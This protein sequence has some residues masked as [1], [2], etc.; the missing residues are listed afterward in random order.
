MDSQVPCHGQ[1][2]PREALSGRSCHSPLDQVPG[3]VG[4]HRSRCCTVALLAVG[5]VP[6]RG[7]AARELCHQAGSRA[8]ALTATSCCPRCIPPRHGRKLAPSSSGKGSSTNIAAD[9][10]RAVSHG[11]RPR[12]G[13][14]QLTGTPDGTGTA[15]TVTA[16]ELDKEQ[17]DQLHA[18]TL[19]AA[20]TCFELKKLC[21]T[22]LVPT[23][24]LVAVFTERRLDTAAFVAGL[25]VITVFWLADGVAYY[26]Q[27]KLRAL[28][29]TYWHK[30]AARCVPPYTA[31]TI[32]RVSSL[33]ALF[34]YSM[35]FYGALAALVG[36]G[37]LL[38]AAGAI[39]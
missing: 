25:L 15:L 3:G 30:R 2:E 4:K 17:I 27:R 5:A 37:W 36:L 24:T 21:A 8:D 38:F 33:G 13:R 9:A 26:Y 7:G 20:D 39:G 11:A 1:Y 31:P 32:S 6:G 22:V 14:T 12:S 29:S 28:M 34:N 35:S 16:D 18:A 10:A 23:A 19:K